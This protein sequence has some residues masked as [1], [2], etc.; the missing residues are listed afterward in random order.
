MPIKFTVH[1]KA[2]ECEPGMQHGSP[3]GRRLQPGKAEVDSLVRRALAVRER[4]E[5][6][7]LDRYGR[8]G[9]R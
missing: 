9:G 6:D 4:A 2:L 7:R 3:Y 1:A 8:F 5:Q